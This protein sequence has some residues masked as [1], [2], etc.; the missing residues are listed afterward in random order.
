[1]EQSDAIQRLRAASTAT[2]LVY[3]SVRAAGFGWAVHCWASGRRYQPSLTAQQPQQPARIV[4]IQPRTPNNLTPTPDRAAGSP[5][6]IT[7]IVRAPSRVLA[8]AIVNVLTRIVGLS[9]PFVPASF[10]RLLAWTNLSRDASLTLERL[11][12]GH[13]LRDEDRPIHA[14]VHFILAYVLAT[15]LSR[16]ATFTKSANKL[17]PKD[18]NKLAAFL[19]RRVRLTRAI[20][21]TLAVVCFLEE[22]THLLTTLLLQRN[23]LML[24]GRLAD[25]GQ[26]T[27]TGSEHHLTGAAVRPAS[28]CSICQGSIADLSPSEAALLERNQPLHDIAVWHRQIALLRPRRRRRSR[29]AE[30]ESFSEPSSESSAESS[31]ESSSDPSSESSS[32][33]ESTDTDTSDV[34]TN[35]G[36]FQ[37]NPETEA[38]QESATLPPLL[39]FCKSVPQHVAHLECMQRWFASSQRGAGLCPECRQPLRAISKFLPRLLAKL[40]DPQYWASLCARAIQT[41]I[42]VALAAASLQA[43]SALGDLVEQSRLATKRLQSRLRLQK[44]SALTIVARVLLWLLQ[45]N[46]GLLLLWLRLM[47]PFALR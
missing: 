16:V 4:N 19:L 23:R 31:S 47:S 32:D 9:P 6:I 28:D 44:T 35:V 45:S 37:P 15:I 2:V 38:P 11:A 21:I 22:L 8:R 29:S 3:Q 36:D 12:L 34:R 13:D 33:D 1:M 25:Q 27:E 30:V 41:S 46:Q 40:S 10:A 43:W 18:R 20:P 26:C 14:G 5:S 24:D 7:A 39:N 42:T 17:P